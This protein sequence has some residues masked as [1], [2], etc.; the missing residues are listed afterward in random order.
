MLRAQGGKMSSRKGQE[1]N[2]DSCRD[3]NGRRLSTVKEAKAL[4]AYLASAPQREAALSKAQSEKYAKLEKMLGRKPRNEVDFQEAAERLDDAGGQLTDGDQTPL[5]VI[6]VKG[7]ESSSSGVQSTAAKRRDR[8]DDDGFIEENRRAVDKAKSA[9]AI[10]MAKKKGKAKAA[11]TDSK[12][13]TVPA[14]AL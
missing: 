11:A 10:A 13:A 9:V 14:A 8:L 6:P 5:N 1:E 7:K 2:T 4:A 3:L 12:T